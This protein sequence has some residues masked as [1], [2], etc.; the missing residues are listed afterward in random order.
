MR[1]INIYYIYILKIIINNFPFP[2]P[3][4]VYH[5]SENVNVQ[6]TKYK[7]KREIQ[8]IVVATFDFAEDKMYLG[9]KNKCQFILYFARLLLNLQRQRD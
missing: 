5:F 3:S 4:S 1:K 7:V 2:F 9:S 6:S 8:S